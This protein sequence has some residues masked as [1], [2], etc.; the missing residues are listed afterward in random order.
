MLLGAKQATEMIILTG[1]VDFMSSWTALVFIG[2]CLIRI[3]A[4]DGVQ[5]ALNPIAL[6]KAT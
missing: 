3:I 5:A 1:A 4:T 6:A 2:V